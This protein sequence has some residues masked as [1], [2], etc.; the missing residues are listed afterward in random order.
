MQA[1]QARVVASVTLHADRIGLKPT[2]SHPWP[3]RFL[4]AKVGVKLGMD[5]VQAQQAWAVA[6]FDMSHN[7]S[8]AKSS[9]HLQSQFQAEI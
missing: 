2:A 8:H 6:N 7:F 3:E 1:Q 4:H 5:H 9:S